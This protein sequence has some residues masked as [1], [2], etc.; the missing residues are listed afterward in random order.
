M[1]ATLNEA[2]NAL[3]PIVGISAGFA[4]GFSILSIVASLISRAIK[5]DDLSP[6]FDPAP[7]P[8]SGPSLSGAN[9]RET[10]IE[11]LTPSSF[12]LTV[13]AAKSSKECRY[14]GT[15]YE[16]KTCPQCGGPRK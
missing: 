1:H 9:A 3:W 5:Y 15:E 10:V 7:W 2:V 4:L 8:S 13:Q 11:Q 16:G 6:S 14:C 12:R